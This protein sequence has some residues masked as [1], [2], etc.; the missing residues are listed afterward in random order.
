MSDEKTF[1]R[2]TGAATHKR[3]RG[4]PSRISDTI[5]RMRPG[6]EGEQPQKV[7]VPITEALCDVMR[8]GNYL[9]TACAQVG[10]DKK[11]VY[12][13][14]KR[15]A[16]EKRG[17][18]TEFR[19]GVEKAQ[20][21]SEALLVGRIVGAGK[22]HWQANAWMLERKFPAKYGQRIRLTVDKELTDAVDRLEVEFRSEPAI[23]ERALRAL[24][25]DSNIPIGALEGEDG[26]ALAGLPPAATVRASSD[27]GV[28]AAEALVEID[29]GAGESLDE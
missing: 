29:G 16:R 26:H 11:I 2:P 18:Y 25:G 21:D 17:K 24:A 6:K 28:R 19:F 12:E 9:E 7:Q 10:I 14:L 23:L 8:I 22:E 3:G 15:G 5:E 27:T 1:S 13:W 20:H 4:R